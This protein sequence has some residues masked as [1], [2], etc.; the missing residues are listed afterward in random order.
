MA[1]GRRLYWYGTS[2]GPEG[3]SS[4][5]GEVELERARR[6]F[7]TWHRPIPEILA[8]TRPEEVE[9]HDLYALPRPLRTLVRGRVALVGDAAHA[10]PP[11]VGQGGCQS[12][13]A[14]VVLAASVTSAGSAVEGLVAYDDARRPR[15]AGVLRTAWAS[16]R[17]GEQLRNPVPVALGNAALRASPTRVL[18]DGM[19]RFS[20]WTPPELPVAGADDPR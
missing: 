19:A 16:A 15:T 11:N 5:D 18:L 9:R 8:A 20:G 13:E 7:A 6:R 4:G 1:D 17:V 10:M 12:I 2:V 14:G 3:G